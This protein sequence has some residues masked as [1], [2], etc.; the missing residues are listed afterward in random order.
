MEL[1]KQLVSCN[2]CFAKKTFMPSAPV[3]APGITG[4]SELTVAL[5]LPHGF[6]HVFVFAPLMV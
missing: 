4:M 5:P 3:C 2:L 1:Y 6:S